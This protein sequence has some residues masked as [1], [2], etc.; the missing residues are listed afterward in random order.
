MNIYYNVQE[1]LIIKEIDNTF[2]MVCSPLIKTN[3][4]RRTS[5]GGTPHIPLISIQRFA[6]DNRTFS[7]P[8]T[9]SHG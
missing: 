9:N 1:M 2:P 4:I 7:V 8:C 3:G 6:T 5:K